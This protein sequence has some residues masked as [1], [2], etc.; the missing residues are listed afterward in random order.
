MSPAAEKLELTVKLAY[1]APS[2]ALAATAIPL[3]VHMPKFYTDTVL[4]PLGYVALAMALARVFDASL[5]PFLGWLSDRTRTRFGRRRPWL[6]LGAPAAALTFAALFTPPTG[7]GPTLAAVWFGTWFLLAFTLHTVLMIPHTALGPELTLDYNERSSLFG[8]R[9]GFAVLGTISAAVVP[10]LLIEA[11]G[12]TRRAFSLM[13]IGYGTLMVALYGLLVLRLRERPEFAAREPN[14]LVPGVRRA[15]RN[16][17]FRIL[18]ACYV[19][20]SVPGGIPALLM[21][22]FNQYVI[23]PDNPDRWLGLFLLAYFGSGFL[24]LPVWVKAAH[25]FGKRPT[26]LLSFA[27]GTTGGAAMFFLGPGDVL[28][29]LAIIAW[30]G[31]SFG[32]SM[33]LTPAIQADVIDYDEL[34]TGKRREAQFGALWL[35]APKFIVI[36]S[37]SLPLALLAWLGY[38]PNLP[39]TPGVVLAIRVMFALVPSVFSVLALLI[40][41]RFPID[42]K[43]HRAILRGIERHH[44]GEP[45]LD[46]LTGLQV[47]APREQTAGEEIG[48][49]L[50]HFSRGELERVLLWGPRRALHDVLKVAGLA[51]ALVI[52]LGGWALYDLSATEGDPGLLAVFAIV[53]A[54]LSLTAFVFH[55]FRVGPALRLR[56]DDP[57]PELLRAHLDARDQRAREL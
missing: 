26:W 23:Q 32:A 15:L 4:L 34:Y 27:M 19:V 39:Q 35:L 47:P 7:L 38:V 25:R 53:A 41:W 16:R 21:P 11:T 1:G 52:G 40:A 9:E 28:P 5:A 37:A 24:F 3:A 54:G 31:T 18:F 6:A 49:F 10:A 44:E 55:L 46:P 8:W 13:A 50:D 43:I 2:F 33:F 48:W 30:S 51:L 57:T 17:P 14:P 29:F 42:E 56:R 45:A 36:P 20:M 12:D 22:Y